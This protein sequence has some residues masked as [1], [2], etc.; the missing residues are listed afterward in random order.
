MA[1]TRNKRCR[2]TPLIDDAPALVPTPVAYVVDTSAE[3]RKRAIAR[4]ED[5][6]KSDCEFLKGVVDVDGLPP[7]DR[8]EIAFAGRSNVGKSSLLNALTRR[9]GLA[10]TSSTPGRTQEINF[11]LLGEDIYLVDLPGYG[12]ARAP[13]ARVKAWNALIRN[14][15]R[16]RP[17]LRRV[18]LLIDA[19]HG[20]KANDVEIAKT[21]DASA[22]SYQAVLTKADKVK[23][24]ALARVIER[25]SLA[26]AKHPAAH[27]QV[28][29]TSAAKS[30]GLAELR[31]EIAGLLS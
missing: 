26:L 7:P 4:G 11:F 8:I 15:L 23:P 13:K 17:S 12:Y 5:L 19:R 25:T 29:V 10:R 30:D 2:V 22:V 21:L 20:I 24:P 31:A 18:F 16:G 28:L 27:P 9:K 3:A 1:Y 6:F 14:Y